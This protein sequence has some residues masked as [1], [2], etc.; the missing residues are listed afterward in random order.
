[1]PTNVELRHLRS[2]LM[3]S[4]ELNITRAAARL[5]VAQQAVSTQIQQLERALGTSLLVR[6][7]R[8][9]TLTGAGAELA[10]GVR[11]VVEDLG[12]L[13]ERVRARAEEPA[14]AA[15]L[16]LACCPYATTP[17]A[18][19][20]A[21]AMESAIP[22]L[23]LDLVTVPTPADLPALL[24][25]GGADAAFLWLAAAQDSPRAAR[26]RTDRSAV[27]V[28]QDHRLAALTSV[29]LADL[30]GE[31]V[32]HPAVLDSGW[33]GPQPSEPGARDRPVRPRP[34]TRQVEDCLLTVARGHGV[35]LAPEPLSRWAT[36]PGVHWLPVRDA[37]PAHLTIVWT[38]RA[39]E[40]LV[41]RLVTELRRFTGWTTA[42]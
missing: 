18:L 24:H 12:C 32:L 23:A 7:S 11:A 33:G 3:V 6:S 5:H 20:A 28:C 19:E 29:R 8:G 41:T 9:V 35:W 16:R 27:A 25:S 21:G 39:P 13:A 15:P 36:A 31:T 26:V 30:S 40:P 10:A 34:P 14:P 2:F 17:F 37:E 38:S 22:G 42:A 1:M 4:Q